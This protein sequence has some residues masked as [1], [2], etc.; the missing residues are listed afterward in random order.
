MIDPKTIK[1]NEDNDLKFT[2]GLIIK[3]KRNPDGS[4][5]QTESAGETEQLEYFT[6]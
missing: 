4:E 2:D 5:V 6:E 3:K 1:A